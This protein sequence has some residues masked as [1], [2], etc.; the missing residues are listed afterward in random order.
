[1]DSC[2][3]PAPPAAA[4]RKEER[5][6]GLHVGLALLLSLYFLSPVLCILPVLIAGKVGV[7]SEPTFDRVRMVFWPVVWLGEK[8]PV[9]GDL[10]TAEERMVPP[11]LLPPYVSAP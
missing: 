2:F 11:S 10:V 9:Y 1:M 7:I 8:V 5:H 3:S 6:A 4:S